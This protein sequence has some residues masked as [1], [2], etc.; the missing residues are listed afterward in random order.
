MSHRG[1]CHYSGQ[2]NTL[3]LPCLLGAGHEPPLIVWLEEVLAERAGRGRAAWREG[4]KY[5]ADG[6]G[7]AL[8]ELSLRFARPASRTSTKMVGSFDKRDATTRPAVPPYAC[9]RRYDRIHAHGPLHPGIVGE[10]R[11]DELMA[12][13]A[14]VQQV[15]IDVRKS[16]PGVSVV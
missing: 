13:R 5:A 3:S 16:F 6:R 4:E 1:R 2:Y 10:T 14:E 7:D 15:N 12:R 9:R 11:L 8:I